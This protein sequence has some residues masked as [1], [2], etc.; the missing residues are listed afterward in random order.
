MPVV[1]RDFCITLSR[2]FLLRA[3]Y[4]EVFCVEV[5][6]LAFVKAFAHGCLSKFILQTK[7][8]TNKDQWWPLSCKCMCELLLYLWTV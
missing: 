4:F 5:A 2:F 3:H 6:Q 7:D 1:L 8:E